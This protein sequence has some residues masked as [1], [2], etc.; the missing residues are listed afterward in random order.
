LNLQILQN[1]TLVLIGSSDIRKEKLHEI[2]LKK[3]E[4]KKERKKKREIKTR[5]KKRYS[6][7][8][9]DT[10]RFKVVRFC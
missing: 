6:H 5:T 9:G 8:Y 4:R 1:S 7:I 10:I 2:L 3:K